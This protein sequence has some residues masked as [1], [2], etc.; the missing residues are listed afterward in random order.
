MPSLIFKSNP[1][2]MT[3][4]IAFLDQQKNE[5]ETNAPTIAICIRTKG[6]EWHLK[7]AKR[8]H[9][10]YKET[11]TEASRLLQVGKIVYLCFFEA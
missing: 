1:E 2:G 10:P 11:I 7:E 9:L 4:S 8:K 3:R 5:A 6:Y